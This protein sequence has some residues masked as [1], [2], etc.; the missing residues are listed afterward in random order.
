MSLKSAY[1]TEDGTISL[2]WESVSNASRYV[3]SVDGRTDIN[4]D[5][6]LNFIL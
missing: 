5:G 2:S 3:L 6:N 4:I 1:G